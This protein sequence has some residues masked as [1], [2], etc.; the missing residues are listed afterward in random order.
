[1]R[2]VVLIN[3]AAGS[4]KAQTDQDV[5]KIEELLKAVGVSAVVQSLQPS[6]IEEYAAKLVDSDFDGVIVAGGD[7]TIHSV[8]SALVGS[9][10]PLGILPL[11]TMNHFA[12][13]LH[14]PLKLED[15]VRVI[16][17]GHQTAVDVGQLNGDFFIN[18]SS[19]GLYPQI[20][21]K[22]EF[23]MIRFGKNKWAS[24]V[25]AA[26]AVMRRLPFVTV[27]IVVEGREMVRTTPFV[28]I[29]NNRYKFDLLKIG[30][31][32]SLE[33]NELCVYIAK[34]M[35]PK[36]LFMLFIRAGLG[37][38]HRAKD[39]DYFVVTSV[40]VE[41]TKLPVDVAMDGEVVTM[42]GPL[43]YKTRPKSLQVIVPV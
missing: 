25:K 37:M 19:I 3:C 18:N 7:G 38:L 40:T 2:Y 30:K 34:A 13:D 29:G 21:K 6:Q 42:D 23:E 16:S 5:K 31:R 10:K 41:S 35:D 9:S 32:E 27:K 22:R 24:M 11:G 20:V 36:H 15:A 1:M 43:E 26:F 33:K 12:K 39:F 4:L 17:E 8:A 28:F 14:I